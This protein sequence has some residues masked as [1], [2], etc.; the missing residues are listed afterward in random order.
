M[1]FRFERKYDGNL[2]D[3]KNV[4]LHFMMSVK[5]LRPTQKESFQKSVL[6]PNYNPNYLGYFNKTMQDLYDD[7]TTD[8]SDIDDEYFDMKFND[9]EN[10]LEHQFQRRYIEE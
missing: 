1:K 3:F 4:D 6:N 5:F 10:I 8:E 2:Y 7:E 9:R